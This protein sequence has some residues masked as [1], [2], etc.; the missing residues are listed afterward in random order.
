VG[1][2]RPSL[3]DS[4][5]FLWAAAPAVWESGVR[6]RLGT[7]R[8]AMTRSKRNQGFAEDA[9][10]LIDHNPSKVEHAERVFG[11]AVIL[12]N[13]LDLRHRLRARALL[14]AACVL[15]Q[16][17]RGVATTLIH[18]SN[19]RYHLQPGQ[20]IV[21][22]NPYTLLQFAVDERVGTESAYH[23]DA[24]YPALRRVQKAHGCS[25]ALDLIGYE[26][27]KWVLALQPWSLDRTDPVLVVYLS[28]LE[29]VTRHVSELSLLDA[30]RAWK[31]QTLVPIEIFIHYTDRGT[32]RNDPQHRWFFDEFGEFVSDRD[33]L[34][35][36]STSQVSLSALSTIGLDLL[37]MD[38]AHFVVV[39][40]GAG[41][42]PYDGWRSRLDSS[43][44]DV[45]RVDDGV[46][47]WLLK[48]RSV[49]PDR[50]QQ[51]F[52]ADA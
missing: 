48:I 17:A 38:I 6:G 21:L 2:N 52:K 20:T 49:R 46:D 26:Q 16:R 37:S 36:S 51:V 18:A 10:L 29:E 1:S 34:E 40:Q 9:V 39:P 30:V 45:L 27:S 25:V 12:A 24:S 42:E 50:F 7:I 3:L 13:P 22:W 43:R 15:P 5:R 35:S 44:T 31:S 23:L 19:L 14:I 8:Q 11:S 33:S 32:A 47:R 28:K 41:S 4:A